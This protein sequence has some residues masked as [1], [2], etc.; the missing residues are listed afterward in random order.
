V[1]LFLPQVALSDKSGIQARQ[2]GAGELTGDEPDQAAQAV[3]AAAPTS[4]PAPAGRPGDTQ[5]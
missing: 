2:A 3:G 1:L 4:V 5:G